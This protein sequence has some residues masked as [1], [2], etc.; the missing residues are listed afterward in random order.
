MIFA[1]ML[2]SCAHTLTLEEKFRNYDLDGDGKVSAAE[3]GEV[4]T[5]ITFLAF[6]LN[7]DGAVTLAE[8]QA[9]EGN[10]AD[11]E[12]KPH[13]PDKDGKVTLDEA[14]ATSKMYKT[15]SERF[16]GIDTNRDGFVQLSEAQAYAAKVKA[17]MEK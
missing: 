7:E 3:Y 5:R 14:L 4:V 6:D 11:A 12:F 13:D 9:L 15:F 16:P 10:E 1:L 8:W 2:S 17:A